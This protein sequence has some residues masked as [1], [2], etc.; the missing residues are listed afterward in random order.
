VS[1]TSI[2]Q[3]RQHLVSEFPL[4]ERVYSQPLVLE[5]AEDVSFYGSAVDADSLLVKSLRPGQA[6]RLQVQLSSGATSISSSP[7]VR[8]TVVVASDSSL[9]TIYTENIDY[10]IDYTAGNLSLKSTALQVEQTVVVWLLPYHVYVQ[11]VD[12]KADF[13]RGVIRRLA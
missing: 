6:A 1:Y 3:I 13:S 4:Q 7:L 9:G 2:D 11:D 5:G 10:V 8:G 12:Y